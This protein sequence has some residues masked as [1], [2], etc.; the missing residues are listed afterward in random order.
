MEK[1]KI[2]DIE[3]KFNN[4]YE[5]IM[6]IKLLGEDIEYLYPSENINTHE[7]LYHSQLLLRM[8]EG[9]RTRFVLNLCSYLDKGEH[10]NMSSFLGMLAAN[11]KNSNWK[12]LISKREI[13]L[14]QSKINQILESDEYK[15]ILHFRNKTYAHKDKNFEN[16]ELVANHK[17]V[18]AMI[19]K[20]IEQFE[21]L[22]G[23]LYN[24]SYQI[25]MMP[26]DKDHNIIQS[27][28]SYYGILDLIEK[29]KYEL[30]ESPISINELDSIF[31]SYQ[32]KITN[33][34]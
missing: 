10:R 12:D 17:D 29:H 33:D 19:K 5:Q 24:T 13:Q 22:G 20:L 31:K 14:E 15:T 28:S 6:M 2:E 32:K 11:R 1:F 21:Y 4:L 27:L 25:D 16:T 18:M 9:I 3:D 7:L 34:V 26:W 23:K 30:N 8:I